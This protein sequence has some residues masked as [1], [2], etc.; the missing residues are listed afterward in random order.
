MRVCG[1]AGLLGLAAFAAEFV[2]FFLHDAHVIF[3]QAESFL[4]RG[5]V[6]GAEE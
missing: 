5:L 6:G 4:S 3:E 2:H 1:A